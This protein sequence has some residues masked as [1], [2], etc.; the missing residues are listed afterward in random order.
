MQREPTP[1]LI[2]QAARVAELL[3]QGYTN[4]RIAEA[5]GVSGPR[6]AQIR[7]VLP[8]L[9]PY[10]G[11][12]VPLDR[13]RSHRD[14]LWGLRRQTLQL[15]FAIRRDLREL[16]EELEAARIDRLLGLRAG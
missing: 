9:A 12:P 11:R 8:N 10:L 14:Q 2:D 3:D 4:R 13:L 5:M 6:I 7:A 16:D 1:H 15:A